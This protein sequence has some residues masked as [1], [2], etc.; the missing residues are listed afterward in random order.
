MNT[1]YIRTFDVLG[2][3][4]RWTFDEWQIQAFEIRGSREGRFAHVE[5]TQTFRSTTSMFNFP[6]ERKGTLNLVGFWLPIIYPLFYLGFTVWVQQNGRGLLIS[7]GQTLRCL[8]RYWRQS[9]PMWKTQ[10]YFQVLAD[11]ES[12]GNVFQF[13]AL[14][15]YAEP[16]VANQEWLQVPP[17]KGKLIQSRSL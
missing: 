16:V 17:L 13:D 15:T 9:D 7:T 2:R 10:R 14:I 12:K 6:L 4:G 8:L 1:E 5:S 11:V 3:L